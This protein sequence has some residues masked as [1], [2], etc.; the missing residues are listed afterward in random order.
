VCRDDMWAGLTALYGRQTSTGD[1]DAQRAAGP[2]C[3]SPPWW[4]GKIAGPLGQAL[5]REDAVRQER[6]RNAGLNANVDA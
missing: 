1:A 3:C 6:V 4:S 2:H 5:R